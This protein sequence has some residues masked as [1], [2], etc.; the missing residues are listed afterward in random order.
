MHQTPD[1]RIIVATVDSTTGAYPTNGR[2][3]NT[4][5]PSETMPIAGSTTA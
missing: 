3:Q 2:R 1:P 4:G 5:S